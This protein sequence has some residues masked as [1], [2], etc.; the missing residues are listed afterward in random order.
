MSTAFSVTAALSV[1]LSRVV[2]EVSSGNS[3]SEVG[4]REVGRS[5]TKSVV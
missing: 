5:N 1:L 3:V 4:V 2:V